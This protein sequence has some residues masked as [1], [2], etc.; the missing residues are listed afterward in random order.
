MTPVTTRNFLIKLSIFIVTIFFVVSLFGN[1]YISAKSSNI[2]FGAIKTLAQVAPKPTTPKPVKDPI[3]EVVP[4]ATS[5]SGITN[6]RPIEPCDKNKGIGGCVTFIDV[7]SFR[8]SAKSGE[9]I[10]RFTLKIANILTLLA[11][12][13][14][15]LVIVLSSYKLFGANGD[16]TKYEAGLN[17]VLYACVGLIVAILSYTIVAVISTFVASP[18]L[19][20]FIS[21]SIF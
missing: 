17:N 14:A 4:P 1:N 3:N 19:I 18:N 11:G 12:A 9:N 5:G 6:G 2:G 15:V 10:I 21:K 20:G 7:E 13:F 16:K 8:A